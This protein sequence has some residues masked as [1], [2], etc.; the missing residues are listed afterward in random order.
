MF[1]KLFDNTS[2]TLSDDICGRNICF[3]II[4]FPDNV[5]TLLCHRRSLPRGWSRGLSARLVPYFVCAFCQTLPGRRGAGG[6]CE[7]MLLAGCAG[8]VGCHGVPLEAAGGMCR[9]SG[10]LRPRCGTGSASGCCWRGVPAAQAVA[11]CLGRRWA[12][13]VGGA[14]AAAGGDCKV[15][16]WFRK[17]VLA[18]WSGEV[19]SH[20]S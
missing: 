1:D 15:P 10:R 6:V 4:E 19:A 14:A 20:F 13:R 7:R 9:R 18:S 5:G 8:R 17:F 16:K 12:A 11:A 3:E 2:D